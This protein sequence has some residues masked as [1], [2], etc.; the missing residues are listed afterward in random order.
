MTLSREKTKQLLDNGVL[1]AYA[2]NRAIEAKNLED[3]WAEICGN[4]VFDSPATSYRVKPTPQ[5]RPHTTSELSGLVG[6]VVKCKKD[7]DM[8]CIVLYAC[9]RSTKI[10]LS[11]DLWCSAQALMEKFVY[12]DGAPIGVKLEQ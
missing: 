11:N 10:K 12:P 7:F 9:P 3:T 8:C 5:Y 6:K 1:Q 4:A 2:H